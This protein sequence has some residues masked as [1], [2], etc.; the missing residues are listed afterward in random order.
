MKLFILSL[1]LGIAWGRRFNIFNPSPYECTH[2]QPEQVH[3]AFGDKSNDIVVTW[4]TFNDTQESRV[5]YGAG[6]MD[7]ESRGS[8]KLF[9][10]GGSLKRSQY[11]HTVVLKNLKYNTKY[12]YHAGSVY[13]WSEMFWFRVPPAGEDWPVRAAIY[14]DM[15]NKNAQSL[16]YLQDEAQRD[17][18]DVILHV[19][20]F[21]YDMDTDEARVGDEFMRQI[22]P[23]AALVP[24]MTC[25]GNHE[26]AYN[27]SNYANR[28]RMPGRDSSLYYSFD[29][30]PIH[31]V[32]IST[33]V[34]YFTQYGL[35]LIVSQYEW[36]KKDLA[37]ANLPQNRA[38]RPWIILFGHRPMYC[39]DS[40]DIDCS[41]EYT[42]VGLLGVYGLEPLLREFRVDAA[43]WAH[44]HSY[45]RTWPLYDN[46]V[47]NGTR[48]PYH[49]PRAPVHIV[50]GSAGCQEKT[51][52]FRPDPEPWS[53]FR[54]SD[55][56]YTRFVAHNKTH[57]YFEQVDVDLLG[58]V[59]DSFW[60]VKDEHKP[61]KI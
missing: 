42:R 46:R 49:N 56:G 2:C 58:E 37:K 16:S 45:E 34:Y 26:Q 5:Q 12:V 51:D 4:S 19:G 38:K 9:V 48:Q 1:V 13:G 33:E 30:G 15:G 43:V 60:I 28:F 31:F 39:S 29:L 8:S 44:E 21:A 61:Y 59:I 50:T 47:Y 24:Y 52:P 53:A 41:C 22:Q 27:F 23:L 35:K 18:F 20:D 36:L 55:Y 32:S 17:K 10:D 6:I 14:G 25:P 40:N 3:I 11:I 57:V 54:S 7:Q